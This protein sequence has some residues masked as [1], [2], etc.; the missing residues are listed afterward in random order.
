MGLW[1]LPGRPPR[2]SCATTARHCP[3]G[4]LQEV[5]ARVRAQASMVPLMVLLTG[6]LVRVLT[7]QRAGGPGPPRARP[8]DWIAG[9]LA[10]ES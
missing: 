3:H 5:R 2:P 7:Q 4:A 6:A 9:D 10:P 8:D 1:R